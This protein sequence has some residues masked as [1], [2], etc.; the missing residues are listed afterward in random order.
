MAKSPKSGKGKAGDASLVAEAPPRGLVDLFPHS[1]LGNAE[2]FV[3]RYANTFRYDHERRVWL[4]WQGHWW[5]QVEESVV[6]R[7]SVKVARETKARAKEKHDEPLHKW[8]LTTESGAHLREM[9]S[10]ARNMNPIAVEQ[11][12]WDQD[13]YL[14]G[15]AN[16][17]I[18]LRTGVFRAG[19]REDGIT[20]HSPVAYDAAATCPTF[21]KFFDEIFLSRVDLS[22]YVIKALGYSMTGDTRERC[23]FIKYGSGN[24]GKSILGSLI[25]YIMGDYGKS[26]PSETLSSTREEGPRNDI[27][28]LSAARYVTASESGLKRGVA[29]ELLKRITGKDVFVA[30]YLHREFF[31]FVPRFKFWLSCNHK[32][33]IQ[34]TDAA[35]WS[36]IPLIPFEGEFRGDKEDKDL[37]TKLMAEAP[38]ILNRLIAG[39]LLWQKEG[40]QLPDCI[41][42]ASADYRS[43]SNPI[44]PFLDACCECDQT[45]VAETS[46]GEWAAGKDELFAAY[47]AYCA[48]MK[49]KPDVK[50]VFGANVKAAGFKDARTN[51][52][53][54]WS[55]VKLTNPVSN[56]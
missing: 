45:Q 53:R 30:R 10:R 7:A 17:V 5:G 38:G 29:E 20:L 22:S 9:T 56:W 12:T 25:G 26:T 36:R 43:E 33:P 37:D 35:I 28:R 2:R 52:A 39:C 40:L 24:N 27:A 42:A 13:A 50:N 54:W 32:P 3:K 41:R 11:G 18:D 51:A 31:E 1:D 47:V 15:V 49:L 48:K 8:M 14:F 16:G 21:D 19:K 6:F 23:L 55:G 46:A 4:A 44:A 34:G